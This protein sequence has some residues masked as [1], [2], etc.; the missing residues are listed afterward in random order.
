MFYSKPGYCF[1]KSSWLI[2]FIVNTIFFNPY[3][4]SYDLEGN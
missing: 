1:L 2:A 4:I 3:T